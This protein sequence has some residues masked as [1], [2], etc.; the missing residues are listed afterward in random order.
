MTDAAVIW[1]SA[2]LHLT[3]R[4]Q[5]GW[6]E[7]SP[8]LLRAYYTR[9]E[10]HPVAESCAAEIALFER[11]MA[12]PAAPVTEADLSAIA[13]RDTAANYA[14]VLRFRDHLIAHGSV[15]A[16]YR[17][18]FEPGAP[19]VPP[20]F[21]D[22]LVHLIMSNLLRGET[23]AFLARAAELFFR[24]QVATTSDEQLL[25]ADAEVVDTRAQSGALVPAGAEP[26]REVE[27]DILTPRTASGYWDRADRF[28]FA[29]DFR[30]AEP[31]QDAF[32]RLIERW[33][34]HFLDLTVR[35]QPLQ[36]VQNQSW[37]WHVGL[38][39]EATRILNALYRGEELPAEGQ[40]RIAA[41]FRMEVAEPDR[42]I[43]RMRGKPVFLGLALDAGN[44]LRMKPQNLLVNLP[45]LPVR[46]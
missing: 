29:L 18:L 9:P 8:E 14:V 42:L 4:L 2:G 19:A 43:E 12:E 22:Q 7:V 33:L 46:Q 28:D 6:L 21:I 37:P 24:D 3:R 26:P 45:L 31:G 34:L 32:A 23:D 30:F 25:L 15:E 40:G 20:M 36:S 17:A 39:A 1:K 10:I 41:L 38:D 13:D 16:G 5:N 27:L 35:V 11:L 44:R